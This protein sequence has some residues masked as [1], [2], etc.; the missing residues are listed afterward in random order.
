M[1]EF[2]LAYF[3]SIKPSGVMKIF[4]QNNLGN[5]KKFSHKES[6][7]MD[8]LTIGALL[9]KSKL[10]FFHFLTVTGSLQNISTT[11]RF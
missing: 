6:C 11:N 2:G 4:Y 5:K 10:A 9:L 1:V 7:A 3:G 8:Q